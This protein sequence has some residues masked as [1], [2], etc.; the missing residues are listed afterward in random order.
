[1]KHNKIWRE[2]LIHAKEILIQVID[3]IIRCL[4]PKVVRRH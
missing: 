1:M 3:I 4:K 2:R